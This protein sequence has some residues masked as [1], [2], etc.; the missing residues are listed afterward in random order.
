MQV[1]AYGVV[2]YV[3]LYVH[4]W[5]CMYTETDNHIRAGGQVVYTSTATASTNVAKTDLFGIMLDIIKQNAGYVIIWT[6]SIPTPAL[7]NGM[8]SP[9]YYG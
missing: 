9:P 3:G 7:Y 5:G 1:S 6:L 8:D 2:Y 4:M